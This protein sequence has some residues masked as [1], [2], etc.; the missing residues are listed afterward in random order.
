MRD[1][2]FPPFYLATPE[3]FKNVTNGIASRRWL[4][5]SNPEDVGLGVE[6]GVGVLLDP[7]VLVQ[8]VQGVQVLALVLVGGM[9]IS[10]SS[11]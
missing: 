5:Q 4:M 10:L 11:A 7:Q 6:G 1:D 3:K 9:T 8:D 2:V